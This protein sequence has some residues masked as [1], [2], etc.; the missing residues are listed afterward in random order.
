VTLVV[1][2]GP[3]KVAVPDVVGKNRDD[4]QRAIEAAGLQ[5][6][7]TDR[8]DA[9]KDPGTVLETSPTAGTRIPKGGTVDLVVA[10]A[11]PKIAV[12]D[13]IDKPYADAKAT[14][15]AAGFRVKRR[16]QTVD[17]QDGDKK[18][19]DQNPAAGEKRDKGTLVL[20]TE[21]RFQPGSPT[22]SPTASPTPSP[23][24]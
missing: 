1:S 3:Q 19:L 15:L 13:V 12:P 7:F 5:A 11:P 8:E 10:K 6:T 21:G 4:A 16:L 18:V 14:L 24:P 20:L 23:T 22:P 17:T 2:R 9:T